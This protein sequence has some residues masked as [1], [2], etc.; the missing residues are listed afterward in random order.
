MIRQS[1]LKYLLNLQ[2]TLAMGRVGRYQG[3]LMTF[4]RPANNKLIDRALRTLRSLA[5]RQP[6]SERR[7]QIY[8]W[9]AQE[10]PDEQLLAALFAAMDQIQPDEPA[11]IAALELLLANAE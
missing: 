5:A 10:A 11:V 3:N 9:I 8:N 4:V 7:A 6:E 2:S 1:I